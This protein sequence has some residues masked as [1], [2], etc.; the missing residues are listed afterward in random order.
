MGSW[1]DSRPETSGFTNTITINVDC[2]DPNAVATA[3]AIVAGDTRSIVWFA[4]MFAYGAEGYE[5]RTNASDCW[6]RERDLIA[7]NRTRS[8]AVWLAD[9]PPDVAWSFWVP[10]PNGTTIYD[11]NRY[12][13]ILTTAAAMVRADFSDLDVGY[14]FGSLP[15][16][17]VPASGVTVLGLESYDAAW[18]TKLQQLEALTRLPLWL[19]SPGFVDGDP[20]ANDPILAQRVRDQWTWMQQDARIVADYWFLWCC[21]DTT[22][23]DKSFYTVSGGQLPVTR[24]TLMDVGAVVIK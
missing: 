15:A 14:N 24:Q 8:L 3:Q 19:M 9:E 17:A 6:Q 21:D 20:V 12:N 2:D 10:G 11:P 13:S 23:G 18:L 4:P 22:T 5:L 16:G 1:Q 7:N